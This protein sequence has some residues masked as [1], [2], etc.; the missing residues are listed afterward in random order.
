MTG[1]NLLN[2]NQAP[3]AVVT[4]W[5]GVALVSYVGR[6]YA[7]AIVFIPA[8]L[9]ALLVNC[10][11]SENKIGLLFSYW[12]SSKLWVGIRSHVGKFM[13]LLNSLCDHTVCDI[14]GL[15]ELHHC[16]TYKEYVGGAFN[17]VLILNGQ[18]SETTTNA[19]VLSAYAI[20]NSAGPFMWKQ[21]YIPRYAPP[22]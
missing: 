17:V 1:S 9:G 10:L 16:R 12:V 4:I 22:V 19:I 11:P 21:K 8:I 7:G 5:S 13:I 6:G 15:G 2:I 18:I 3:T 14:L 20:G